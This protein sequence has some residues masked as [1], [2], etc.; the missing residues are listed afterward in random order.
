MLHLCSSSELSVQDSLYNLGSDCSPP[1]DP[2][3][4]HSEL[5]CVKHL[6]FC[7]GKQSPIQPTNH[8]HN[9]IMSLKPRGNHFFTQNLILCIVCTPKQWDQRH[10]CPSPVQGSSPC[11]LGCVFLHKNQEQR[12]RGGSRTRETHEYLKVKLMLLL[13]GLRFSRF[14]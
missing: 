4:S 12:V 11:V 8:S 13:S 6:R 7:F 14:S 1:P 9:G 5:I 2:N 10:L 3:F